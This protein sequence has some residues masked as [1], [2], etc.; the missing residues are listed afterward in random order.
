MQCRKCWLKLG[1]FILMFSISHQVSAHDQS[2]LAFVRALV[3]AQTK[4]DAQAED[5]EK[6]GQTT[7]MCDLTL[8][9]ADSFAKPTPGLIR[10]T[11]LASGKALKLTG[12][13]HRALN[14][15]AVEQT[16]TLKVPRTELKIEAIR[17]LQSE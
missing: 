1:L 6:A 7:G 8:E 9:I 15:Y 13:I 17:G 14:W 4:A 3:L 5:P 11:N 12:E 16:I 10:L 2:R